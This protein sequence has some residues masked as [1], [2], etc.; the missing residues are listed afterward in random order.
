MRL[1]GLDAWSLTL[2][3]LAVGALLAWLYLRK[4]PTRRRVV[5]ALSL[6]LAI[7]AAGARR[8]ASRTTSLL[9]ALLIACLLLGALADPRPAYA[10]GDFV[11]LIERGIAMSARDVP[12]TRLAEAKRSAHARVDALRPGDRAQVLSFAAQVTAHSELSADRA[13]LHAAIDR[14]E[15]SDARSDVEA[16]EAFVRGSRVVSFGSAEV[17]AQERVRVGSSDRNVGIRAFGVRSYPLDRAHASVLVAV[18]N[19]GSR[20]ERVTL[21][22]RSDVVLYEQTLMLEPQGSTTRTLDDLPALAL[23]ASITLADGRDALP[24][25]DRAV[26]AS[27]ARA[28][29]VLLVSAGDRYLEAALLVDPALTLT[30][31]EA[32]QPGDYDVVIFDRTQPAQDPALPALY[33]GAPGDSFV[34][35]PYFDRLQATPLLAGLALRDVNITRAA[36]RPLGPGD[37]ALASSADGTPLLI[38]GHRRAPFLALTFA[39]AESDLALRAAFPVFVQRAI[40]QLR[41]EPPS[42]E[43]HLAGEPFAVREGGVLRAPD[44]VTTTLAPNARIALERAG[45]YELLADGRTTPLAIL[46]HAGSIAPQGRALPPTRTL[47]WYWPLLAL[48]ALLLLAFEQIAYRRGWTQ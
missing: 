31:A 33:L 25:D 19:F 32:F 46:P 11:L 40:D 34:A 20:S 30:R 14:I 44:G 24:A 48:L 26:A 28:P 27:S 47:A 42:A 10:P 37:R 36:S 41:G 18:T 7:E 38:E 5:P 15:A 21:R 23:E 29:R 17:H 12:G 3:L 4:Q 22:V 1:F 6:W 16:A 2:A 45:R 13:R 35:R 9:L 43:S 8:F 39:L